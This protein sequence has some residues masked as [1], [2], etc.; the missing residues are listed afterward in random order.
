M[1]A[2]K[3]RMWTTALDKPADLLYYCNSTM[4]YM[5]K[6]QKEITE[7]LAQI[8]DPRLMNDFLSD[9]LTPEEYDNIAVRWQ[10]V[11]MLAKNTPQREISKI[12]KVAIATITRGSRELQNPTGG[13]KKVLKL[14][15]NKK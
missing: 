6:S 12:L 3:L 1:K 9:L 7:L 10:L 13:F 15:G 11:K 5:K 2:V 14:Y 4:K 8:K